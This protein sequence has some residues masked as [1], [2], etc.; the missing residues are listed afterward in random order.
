MNDSILDKLYKRT[1]LNQSLLVNIYKQL[2]KHN[3]TISID[4]NAVLQMESNGPS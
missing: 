1:A 4:Q 2:G 3:S